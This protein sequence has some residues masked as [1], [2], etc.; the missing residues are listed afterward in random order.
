MDLTWVT[1][2]KRT[3]RPSWCP[4]LDLITHCLQELLEILHSI[5]AYLLRNSLQKILCGLQDEKGSLKQQ[6]PRWARPKTSP[7]QIPSPAA[8]SGRSLGKRLGKSCLNTFVG[9]SSAFISA[10]V[11]EGLKV[12]GGCGCPPAALPGTRSWSP[13]C[14]LGGLAALWAGELDF[15][16]SALHFF[17]W[18]S[19]CLQALPCLLCKQVLPLNKQLLGFIVFFWINFVSGK[20][21]TAKF[22]ADFFHVGYTGAAQVQEAPTPGLI[23]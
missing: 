7:A 15:P 4:S 5:L 12:E 23:S 14:V 10:G 13:A 17:H 20:M 21:K 3:L 19:S 2:S 6:L 9:Q 11:L 18:S 1:A 8:V 22:P 16:V